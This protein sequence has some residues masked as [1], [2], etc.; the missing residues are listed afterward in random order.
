MPCSP[1]QGREVNVTSLAGANR[2]LFER[3]VWP[4]DL[5]DWTR[6]RRCMTGSCVE[7]RE[8]E[9]GRLQIRDSKQVDVEGSEFDTINLDL[10]TF[11]VFQDEL[12]GKTPEGTNGEVV[13]DRLD[14]GWVAFRS[15]STGVTL[16]YNAE[17]FVAFIEGV[18][19]GDFRPTLVSA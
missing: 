11:I 7:I 17:E 4:N 3:A 15:L 1:G 19:A 2:Y 14:D 10:L 12:V 8:E 5:S 18:R 9:P 16:R 6:S 13:I